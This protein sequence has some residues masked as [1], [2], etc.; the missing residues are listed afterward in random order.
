MQTHWDTWNFDI[1]RGHDE[2]NIDV[3]KAS[4]CAHT[5]LAWGRILN[6]QSHEHVDEQHAELEAGGLLQRRRV[7]NFATASTA[8]NKGGGLGRENPSTLKVMLIADRD[9]IVLLRS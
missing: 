7:R 1:Q 6:L 9:R 3:V 5:N 8:S 2:S 4:P